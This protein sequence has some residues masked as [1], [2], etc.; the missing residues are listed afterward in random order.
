MPIPFI[1]PIPI[2]SRDFELLCIEVLRRFWVLPS[3]VL[4]AKSGEEQNGVDI[5]DLGGGAPL[6]A[7]QCKLKEPDKSLA[8]GEIQAEVDKAKTFELT[9]GKYAILTTG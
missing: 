5:I 8:P 6:H 4:Y 9:I 1:A 3:L 2:N 7:A